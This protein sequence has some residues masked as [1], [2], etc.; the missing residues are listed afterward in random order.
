MLQ[1]FLCEPSQTNGRLPAAL[2]ILYSI[3]I[4]SIYDIKDLKN[5]IRMFYIKC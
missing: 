1:Q 5:P 4:I 2:R 3:D